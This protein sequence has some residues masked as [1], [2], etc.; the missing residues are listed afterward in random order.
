[1]LGSLKR[2]KLRRKRCWTEG[3][4]R[5]CWM[6]YRRPCKEGSSLWIKLS[7]DKNKRV[8]YFYKVNYICYSFIL[9]FLLFL[10]L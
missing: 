4:F 6:S 1:M 8:K 5:H 2:N 7:E 9:Y 10:I 3:K